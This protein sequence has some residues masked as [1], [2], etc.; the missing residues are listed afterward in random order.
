MAERIL[1]YLIDQTV[2]VFKDLSSLEMVT[3]LPRMASVWSAYVQ[4]TL[5]F[6][7]SRL[8]KRGSYKLGWVLQLLI[9]WF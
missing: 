3:V 8:V 2:G 5:I 7:L 1:S 4:M 6:F 9:R